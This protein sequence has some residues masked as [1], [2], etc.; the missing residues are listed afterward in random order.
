MS[1]VRIP[2]GKQI[3]K[4]L[5]K[6]PDLVFD[7]TVIKCLPC[8]TH[9][10]MWSVIQ[11]RNHVNSKR[12]IQSQER[13]W[14]YMKFLSDLMFMLSV[15]D[16]PFVM[17]IEESFRVF[18]NKYVPMWKLP[19]R[20]TMYR[21]LQLIR[22]MVENHIRSKVANRKIWITIDKTTD[23]YNRKVIN[24]LIRPMRSNQSSVPYLIASKK[25]KN[26]TAESITGVVQNAIARFGIHKNNVLM[27]VT[28][29]TECMLEA[30]KSLKDFYPKLLHVTCM[31]QTLHLVEVQIRDGYSDIDKLISSTKTVFESSTKRT[32]TFRKRCPGIPQPPDLIGTRWKPWLEAVFYYH[33]YFDQVKSF[34]LEMDPND[35]QSIE[36]SKQLFEDPQVRNNL[37]T[38]Y[39]NYT[40]LSN[41]IKQLQDSTSS[42]SA[43]LSAISNVIC[44]LQLQTVMDI[45]GMLARET[46]HDNLDKSP[47]YSKLCAIDQSSLYGNSSVDDKYFRYA[48]MTCINME[49]PFLTHIST[50]SPRHKALTETTIEALLMFEMFSRSHPA[51]CQQ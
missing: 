38:L 25:L 7:G 49:H 51:L 50:F 34:V 45:T 22:Q 21:K 37:H 15:C 31:L 41:A 43:S 11:C 2:F 28:D 20:K 39:N 23:I 27:L 10:P 4:W 46:L 42:L 24:V 26:V 44:S 48:N 33:T 12:H 18:W 14:P 35:A 17:P 13:Q 6:Y 3:Q 5:V 36:T 32:N 1:K 47:D 8:E 16:L 29:I 19:P 30:G 40:P 9:L